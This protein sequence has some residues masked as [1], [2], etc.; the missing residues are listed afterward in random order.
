MIVLQLS[1]VRVSTVQENFLY[2]YV[3]SFNFTIFC[4]DFSTIVSND[5]NVKREILDSNVTISQSHINQIWKEHL[6]FLRIETSKVKKRKII[7]APIY[8]LTSEQ[9]KI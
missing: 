6:H 1:P 2:L 3:L 7:Q 8:A 9:W 5:I 4:T